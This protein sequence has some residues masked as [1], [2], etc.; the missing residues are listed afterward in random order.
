MPE[1]LKDVCE[2]LLFK[3]RTREK[4]KQALNQKPF[5]FY[6]FKKNWDGFS[7]VVQL[8]SQLVLPANFS[9]RH[10]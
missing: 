9:L 3:L 4:W 10:L 1:S 5:S 2:A 8:H 6:F 7:R